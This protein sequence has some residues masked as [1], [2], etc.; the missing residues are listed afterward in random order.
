M[1]EGD[2][3]DLGDRR[4][5]VLHLPGHSPGSIGLLDERNGVLLSGDTLYAGRLVDDLPGSDLMAD[6]RTTTRLLDLDLRAVHGDSLDRDG[7]RAIARGYLD[8]VP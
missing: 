7:M 2:T 1:E 8:R 6:C 5:T 4:L 3:V